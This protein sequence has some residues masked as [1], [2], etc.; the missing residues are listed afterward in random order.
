MK[1]FLVFAAFAGMSAVALGAF[2]A[3]G[4]KNTLSPAMLST[5]QTAVQYQFYH[6][7]ALIL[8]VL[9][10][11]Q[12]GIALLHWSASFM[13]AG[14]LLFCG[15]LYL[16]VLTGQKWL[17]PVTPLGGLCFIAGWLLLLISIVRS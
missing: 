2:A 8:L 6:T 13:T 7:F 17:G 11:R 9:L 1:Y 15:S 5:F 14:I 4:L 16:L 12:L 10:H 3:H